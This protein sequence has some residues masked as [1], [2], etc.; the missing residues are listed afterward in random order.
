MTCAA[1]TEDK[2]KRICVLTED[3]MLFLKIKYELSDGFEVVMSDRR[4]DPSDTLLIDADDPKFSSEVGL[5]MS[6]TEGDILIPFRIGTLKEMLSENGAELKICDGAVFVGTRAIRLTEVELALF[7]AL[8]RRGGEYVTRED[9]I[10]E[11]WGEGADAG[12]LNVYVHYLRG[13]LEANGERVI[14]CT[15]G[16]GYKLNEKYFGGRDA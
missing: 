15:R 5:R 7:S 9:L 3:E 10:R 8:Y 14:T 2:M 6:R 12:I 11:V 4:T 16:R 13:K 1:L